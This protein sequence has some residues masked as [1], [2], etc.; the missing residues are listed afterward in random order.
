MNKQ[1]NILLI[2]A[3]QLS[4]ESLGLYG[5]PVVRTPAIETLA[6]TGVLFNHAYCNYPA[7]APSRCSL[8]T[9][10]YTHTLRNHANHMLL[11]PREVSVVHTLKGA[12]YTTTL[13]GK[14]HAFLSHQDSVKRGGSGYPEYPPENQPHI[15]YD[16]LHRVFDHVQEARH[17]GFVEGFEDDEEMF[18][19][20][21]WAL[22]HCWKSPGSYG[23]NPV[24]SRHQGSYLI[25]TA[26]ERYLTAVQKNESSFFLCVSFPDPHTPYQAPEPYAS[27]YDPSEIPLPPVDTLEGKPERQRVAHLMDT[28]DMFTD[29]H[30]RN[31]RAKHYGMTNFVDDTIARILR[32]L[33]ELN[34]REDTIIVFT[35]DHGD[36]MGAHGLIQKQNGFY[37]SFCRI[38]CI[39]SWPGHFLTRRTDSLFELVDLT[40]TLLSLAGIEPHP[41]IQGKD[42]SP[43][44]L[45]KS[46][47]TKEFIVIESGEAG[48]PPPAVS[49]ITFRPETPWDESYFVWCA[50]REAW[51]GRG[52]A[53]R[54]KRWKLAV[55]ENG[56]GEL[57]D[58]IKDPD[59]LVNLHGSQAD[60]DIEIELERKLLRWCIAQ[61]DK[62]PEN[63]THVN[64]TEYTFFR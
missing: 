10:R 3:D 8:L 48:G 58:M 23:T 14:N 50:Y 26:A 59:E 28:V 57:Y 56:D 42:I 54:T 47:E 13:I 63:K 36:S 51:F 44:L 52:K 17:G 33:D 41:G 64:T 4:A 12:G 24:S 29:E 43:F 55:Y 49:D 31:I 38:P 15:M 60:K 30:I 35:A 25:G 39:F 20:S 6:D 5:N 2:I 27:M 18:T 34:M 40:P 46:D 62:I 21:E 7:C 9:G 22:K 16:E 32:R 19:A 11:D 53:I 1:P 45:G 61:D 37:D